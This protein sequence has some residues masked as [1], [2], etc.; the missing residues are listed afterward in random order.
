MEQSQ[1]WP[2][3]RVL[4]ASTARSRGWE[5]HELRAAVAAGR[6][7]RISRGAYV[8]AATWTR[9]DSRDRHLLLMAAA[10]QRLHSPVFS[11]RSAAA[12]HGLPVLGPWPTKVHVTA[13]WASGGRSQLDVVRHCTADEAPTAELRG[14]VVTD[15]ARTVVDLVRTESFACGLVVADAALHS[16]LVEAAHLQAAAEALHSAQGVGR[17]RQVLA[18]A[19]PQVESPGESFGRARFLQLGVPEPELQHEI[20]VRGR[21]YRV[22]YWWPDP[23]LVGEFDGRLKYTVDGLAD[24]RRAIEER[25]WSEKRREDDLR[26]LGLRVVR[27][28]WADW[29]DEDALVAKL[30]AVGLLPPAHLTT[31]VPRYAAR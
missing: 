28:V 8:D 26:S 16:G 12:V 21:R 9:A 2:A 27:F 22:D 25:L 11:H 7:V 19:S 4:L 10:G 14:F 3:G 29:L 5:A 13:G 17:L 1:L 30:V 18:H 20:A 23:G 6:V 24:D 15:L 31:A